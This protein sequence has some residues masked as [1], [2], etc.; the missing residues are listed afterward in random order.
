MLK[1]FLG[2]CIINWVLN[3]VQLQPEGPKLGIT[4]LT[5][6][7]SP[8]EVMHLLYTVIIIKTARDICKFTVNKTDILSD[9]LN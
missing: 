2:E 1:I 6:L 3:L 7:L 9:H 5:L 8:F 4:P